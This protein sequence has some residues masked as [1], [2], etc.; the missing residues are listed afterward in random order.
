[1]HIRLTKKKLRLIYLGSIGVFGTLGF[2]LLCAVVS[3]QFFAVEYNRA[4]AEGVATSTPVEKP[5]VPVLDKTLYDKLYAALVN[6]PS[7]TPSTTPRIWPAKTPYPNVGAILPFRRIIAYYGNFYSK[8]MGVLGKYPTEE[9]IKRFNVELDKWRAADPTMPPIPAIDY[10]AITAQASPGADGKYR[11]RMPDKEID[12]AV[13]LAKR[14]NGIVILDIQIGLSNLQTELPLLEKYL[15]MPEVHLA[16]DP[17]FAMHNKQKPGSVIGYFTAADVN[18]AANYLAKLVRDNNLPPK[19]LVVHRFTSEMVSGVKNI[20]PLPEVQI[21]MDMDGW[22][23]PAK[24]K[25][26]YQRTIFAEPVQF[27]GFK[28][29]YVNDLKAPSTHILTPA[30]VLDLNPKPVFVQ[31]Q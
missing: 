2:L 25:G 30:E 14:M 1:M 24:K 28:L 27:T 29:F 18:Y 12:K 19:V 4:E 9:M 26:T 16:I 31:F 3:A 23:T 7:S 5:V 11:F 13:E 6:Y 21:V 15:K 20:T 8:Q 17:E 22:G 10:I